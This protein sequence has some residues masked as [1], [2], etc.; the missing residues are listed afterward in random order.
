MLSARG[1]GVTDARNPQPVDAHTVFRLASL[2]KSFA[3][4]VTGMLVNDGVLRWDSHLTDYVPEFPPVAAERRAAGHRRRRAQP[5]RRPDPQRLR[6]RPRGQRG[7]PQPDHEAGQRADEMRARRMLCLP[8]RRLQPDRRRGVRHHRPV[9]QRDRGAPHL[10]AAR[11]ARRQLRPGRHPGQRALGA[12]A[13]A[14]RRR[15]GAAD[16][17]AHLLP[18]RARSR[19]QRQHQRHGAVAAGADRASPRRAA[20]PAAGHP[21]CASG[22]SAPRAK[23]GVRRGGARD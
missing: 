5:S 13:R 9:L 18:C 16:T 17:Q 21:A 23:S 14:R 3:G 4:T 19:R 12:P 1:Y 7:L 11:H 20:R 15:L 6:P 2:S 22:R 10:Q 8:E